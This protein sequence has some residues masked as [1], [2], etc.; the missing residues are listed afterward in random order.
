MLRAAVE[1]NLR[2]RDGSMAG[3]LPH[4]F[5]WRSITE[6]PRQAGVAQGMEMDFIRQSDLSDQALKMPGDITDS[7]FVSLGVREHPPG[8]ARFGLQHLQHKIVHRNHSFSTSLYLE[9]R[10]IVDPDLS[11]IVVNVAPL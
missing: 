4:K 2:G 7:T 1:I 6:Q 8:G 5:R 11:T 9:P 3:Y 10:H